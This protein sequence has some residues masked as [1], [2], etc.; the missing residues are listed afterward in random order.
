MSSTGWTNGDKLLTEYEK[1]ILNLQRNWKLDMMEK[2]V[3]L[4]ARRVNTKGER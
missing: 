1:H 4:G 2:H 3:W